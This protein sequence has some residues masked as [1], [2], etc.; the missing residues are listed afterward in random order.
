M[1][2][3]KWLESLSDEELAQTI[4]GCGCCIHDDTN[5]CQYKTE[6]CD[7]ARVKW[8]QAEHKGENHDQ[9]RIS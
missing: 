2:N 7:E 3:R 8:L 6:T 1:T 5:D 9:Q 4:G